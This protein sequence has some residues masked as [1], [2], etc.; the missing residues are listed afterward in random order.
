MPIRRSLRRICAR[1]IVV[2]ATAAAFDRI[3]AMPIRP[4]PDLHRMR[5][6]IVS[7]TRKV[8]RRVA[9]HA[10]RMAQDGNDSLAKAPS[11]FGIRR[12]EFWHCA[13]DV[14]RGGFAGP[15]S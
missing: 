3:H 6:A 13:G 4:A 15:G 7:L 1:Q 10:T 12:L 2:L 11:S 8:S 14:G 9:I 5:M